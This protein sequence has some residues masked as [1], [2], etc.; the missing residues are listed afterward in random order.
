MLLHSVAK[1]AEKSV[2]SLHPL[3]E[4]SHPKLPFFVR[5]GH[6]GDKIRLFRGIYFFSSSLDFLAQNLIL[7]RKNQFD[8]VLLFGT[9]QNFDFCWR[10]KRESRR[11]FIQPQTEQYQNGKGYSK[12]G[13]SGS[14]NKSSSRKAK[15]QNQKASVLHRKDQAQASKTNCFLPPPPLLSK[16]TSRLSLQTSPL[17]TTSSLVLSQTS[18][19]RHQLPFNPTRR[20]RAYAYIRARALTEFVIFAF[21]L[22]LTAQQTVYQS[23]ECEG[24]PC[25]HLHL[26]R[27]NLIY[28]TLRDFHCK[29]QVKAK[30]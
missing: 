17:F 10:G 19:P 3:P 2:F 27:N 7:R 25:I 20:T 14:K 5:S 26:H 13:Q 15:G 4:I 24:K 6:F 11:F 18:L 21:T 12:T 9:R 8:G 29:K 22:H 30:G 16:N 23:L 1:T 28:N